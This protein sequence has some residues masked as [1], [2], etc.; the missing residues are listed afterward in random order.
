MTTT[1]YRIKCDSCDSLGDFAATSQEARKV[2][3]ANGWA[4]T[5]VKYR[6]GMVDVCPVC[7]AKIQRA[8]RL[9]MGVK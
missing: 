9:T 8:K 3:K 1:L 6:P 7:F 2:A 5:R 4:Y